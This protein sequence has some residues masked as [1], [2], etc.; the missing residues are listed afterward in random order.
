MLGITQ[1]VLRASQAILA[2]CFAAFFAR[3]SSSF[4]ERGKLC[5]RAVPLGIPG[6]QLRMDRKSHEAQGCF[7]AWEVAMKPPIIFIGYAHQNSY[8]LR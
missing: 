1:S 6:E 5:C 2:R 8:A 4:G 7:F 3:R